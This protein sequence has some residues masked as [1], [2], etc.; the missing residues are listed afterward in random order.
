MLWRLLASIWRLWRL[1]ASIGGYGVYWRLWRLL[2]SI[3]VYG[4]YWRLLV[5]AIGVYWWH[6]IIPTC[7]HLLLLKHT[8]ASKLA[9]A[10]FILQRAQQLLP[11]QP[12]LHFPSDG[13]L[14][15]AAQMA[16]P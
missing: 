4:G 2:V 8:P 15:C 5:A 11:V 16:R 6:C 12:Q 7:L 1:L 13:L 10:L 9:A 14:P 3:G